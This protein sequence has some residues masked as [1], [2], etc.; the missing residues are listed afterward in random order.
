VGKFCIDGRIRE[1]SLSMENKILLNV[2]TTASPLSFPKQLITSSKHAIKAEPAA[3]S[4]GHRE[5]V[6]NNH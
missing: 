5:E 6:L 2:A 4:E 3:T 1:L